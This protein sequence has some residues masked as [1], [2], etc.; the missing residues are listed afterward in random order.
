VVHLPWGQGRRIEWA[1]VIS[2]EY[3]KGSGIAIIVQGQKREVI[4]SLISGSAR[5]IEDAQRRLRA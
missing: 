5:F 4:T 2:V 1:E 3:I